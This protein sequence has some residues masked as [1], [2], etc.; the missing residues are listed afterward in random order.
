MIKLISQS[1]TDA[2][3]RRSKCSRV[4]DR[5]TSALSLP[6]P[7]GVGGTTRGTRGVRRVRELARKEEDEEAMPSIFAEEF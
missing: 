7:S 4:I 5:L 3:H 1:A 6:T 2:F